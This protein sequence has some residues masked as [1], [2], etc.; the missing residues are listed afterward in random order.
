MG[1]NNSG[2][3]ARAD[4]KAR[5]KDNRWALHRRKS[6]MHRRFQASMFDTDHQIATLCFDT[7]Q[8]CRM[9]HTVPRLHF[10]LIFCGTE[11]HIHIGVIPPKQ[12]KKVKMSLCT[13]WRHLGGAQLQLHWSVTSAENRGEWSASCNSCFNAGEGSTTSTEQEVRWATGLVWCS[14]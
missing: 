6:H 2:Q 3:S 12:G 7:T 11:L 9:T 8:Y 10:A 4:E 1:P 5:D 14:G 13:P